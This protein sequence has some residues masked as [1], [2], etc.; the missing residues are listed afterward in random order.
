MLTDGSWIILDSDNK[1]FGHAGAQGED[2]AI[3]AMFIILICAAFGL[4]NPAAAMGMAAVGVIISFA[5]GY[6]PV[7]VAALIGFLLVIGLVIFK[8]KS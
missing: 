1:Y 3:Y 6:L 4:F 8:L 2:G 5:L 7:S